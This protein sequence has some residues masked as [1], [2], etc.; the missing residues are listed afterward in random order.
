MSYKL[1]DFVLLVSCLIFCEASASAKNNIKVIAN[2]V[3]EPLVKQELIN[4]AKEI[5]QRF[6][7]SPT[8]S[9]KSFTQILHSYGYYKSRI[10]ISKKENE[11]TL[12]NII[13][14]QRYS[15][16]NINIEYTDKSNS[17]IKLDALMDIGIREG[18]FLDVKKILLAEKIITNYIEKNHCLLSLN[19]QHKAKIID[20][21]NAV[22]IIFDIK[23]G[24]EAKIKEIKFEGLKN[25]KADYARKLLSLRNHECFKREYIIKARAA[26]Q[27]TGLFS[28]TIPSI[29]KVADENGEVPITFNV[30]E[31]NSK[32]IKTGIS[33]GT[34]LGIGGIFGWEHRNLLGSGEELNSEITG[35]QKEKV[36]G[37]SYKK[38]FFIR[39][40]QSLK[41]ST[42]LQNRKL[43]AFDSKESGTSVFVERQISPTWNGGLGLKYS[44]SDVENISDDVLDKTYSIIGCPFFINHDTR[45]NILDSNKGYNARIDIMPLVS[46]KGKKNPFLKTNLELSSYISSAIKFKPTAAFKIGVGIINGT[47]TKKIPVNE[48]FYLGGSNSMRGYA[49]QLVGPLDRNNRPIGG[50]SFINTSAELR[51]HFTDT[52]GIVNFIDSGYVYN[53]YANKKS[54][55][56][57]HSYG[58]GFRYN[59][60]FGPI[61]LDIGFPMKRRKNIDQSYQVYFGIGQSF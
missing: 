19:V 57:L 35:N 25:I 18:D 11:E 40:D 1:Q 20:N 50:N 36:F 4:Q 46:T 17:K 52:I 21:R 49:Y 38:P 44:Y 23:S 59:T 39:D 26:L 47:K 7:V 32:T 14:G 61:R 31:R 55:K 6:L 58:I 34:D 15:I 51:L 42:K 60:G 30:S 45:D 22:E 13:P 43:K 33:Y 27:E 12:L 8:E 29:P 37:I 5:E 54:R 2:G 41:I 56:L 53:S 48:R 9:K 10:Y 3:A 16:S 24:D 28:S